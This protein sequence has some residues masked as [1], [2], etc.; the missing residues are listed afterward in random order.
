MGGGI[1]SISCAVN[2]SLRLTSASGRVVP[3]RS[4]V[5]WNAGDISHNGIKNISVIMCLFL[6]FFLWATYRLLLCPCCTVDS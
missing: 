2:G 6:N 3:L 4:A 1:T 5:K